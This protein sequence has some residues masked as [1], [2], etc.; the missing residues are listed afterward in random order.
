MT[1]NFYQEKKLWKKG[2]K[3]VACLDESGRGPLAGPVVAA[4]TVMVKNPK[5]Q[6]RLIAK[7]LQGAKR[8][9]PN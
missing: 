8:L 6:I 7:Q 1:P 3:R 9:V 5:S 4:T 2:Y